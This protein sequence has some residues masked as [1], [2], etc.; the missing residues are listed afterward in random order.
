MLKKFLTIIA[1]TVTTSAMAEGVLPL[2]KLNAFAKDPTSDLTGLGYED[3]G[4]VAQLDGQ[5]YYSSHTGIEIGN[6]LSLGEKHALLHHLLGNQETPYM[7]G[8]FGTVKAL[9]END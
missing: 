3:V 5:A 2:D 4:K 7:L 8:F 9:S 1:L 6:L